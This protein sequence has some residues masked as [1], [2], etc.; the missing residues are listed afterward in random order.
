MA[1]EETVAQMQLP[2]TRILPRAR[3]VVA[4]FLLSA[5]LL[6]PQPLSAQ[7]TSDFFRQ[8]CVSCHTIGGGRLTGPDLKNVGERQ[9]RE[10]LVRFL[11]NPGAVIQ[12]GDS[13]AQQLY[14]D[15][16]RV[17]MPRVS[18]MTEDR[19]NALLDLIEAES[20]LEESQLKGL[21]ISD[22]PFTAADV[23]LGKEFF[24]G[25]RALA[26]GGSMCLG[27]HTVRG[28]SSL[29]GGRLGPDLSRAYERLGGRTN[30]GAWLYA[31]ATATMGPL[32]RGHPLEAEEILSLLAYFEDAA[33]RGG[34]D[35]TVALLNF[36]FLGLG[37]TILALAIFDGL[38]KK[39]FRGVRAALVERRRVTR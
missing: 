10:W 12:S 22:R 37:G 33:K 35:D 5:V 34:E 38:W 30:M 20:A 24:T 16:R 9:E 31:P 23:A 27:C 13:Y 36:F 39:R 1:K 15:A 6:A 3:T 14:E 18:G 17:M 4:C 11:L 28:L 29:S 8:R 26:N 7:E 2:H 19:A 32:F 21:R 25:N